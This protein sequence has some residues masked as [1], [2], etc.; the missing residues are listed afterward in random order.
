[1]KKVLIF[2]L[3][4]VLSFS[5]FAMVACQQPCET[6]LDGN[7]DGI[8]DICDTEGLTVTHTDSNHDGK[9]DAGCGATVEVNHVD[10]A[11]DGRCDVCNQTVEIVHADANNDG[12]CD[13]CNVLIDHTHAD[14]NND[15]A[16][17]VP[18]CH[19]EFPWVANLASAKALVN[20][21]YL[22]EATLTPGNYTLTTTVNVVGVGAYSVTWT[23]EVA[24]ADKEIVKLGEP[25]QILVNNKV[26]HDVD[27][28]IVAVIA[29]AEGH[30]TTVSFDRKVPK[31]AENTFAEYAAA[32]DGDYLVVKGIVVA[33][34]SKD[35]G[36]TDNS[37]YIVD[38]D[39]G[40]YVYGLTALPEGVKVGDTV[41]ASG[42]KKTYNGTYE[43]VDAAVEIVDATTSMPEPKDFTDLYKAAAVAGG[44]SKAELVAQQAQLVT[45]KGVT[46]GSV[47]SNG[48]RHFSLDGLESYVRISSSN[49]PLNAADTA[50]FE[51][52]FPGLFGMTAD[53]TGLVTLYNG[54]FYLTPISVDA[55]SNAKLPELSDAEKVAF[56]KDALVFETE[57]IE[58][59]S[60]ELP[61]AG[62]AYDTVA[63]AWDFKAE[64]AHDCATI[65]DGKL[66]VTLPKDATTI[67]LVATLTCGNETATKE[68]VVK[69]ASAKIDWKVTAD[70]LA[71]C[72]A[73]EDGAT[74]E[75]YY[76]FYGTVGEIY[77]TEYCNFYLLDAEGNSI[78]VYG[79]YAPNGTDRYGSKRQISEIPFKEGDLIC[80]RAQVQKFVK[81]GAITPELVNAVHVV[82][83]EKGTEV[84]V[85][86]NA[87]EALAI[88]DALEN[89]ATTENFSYF[90][91][92]VGE[93]YNTGYCNFYLTDANGGSIVVY[94][95][96]A[97]N[98][99]DRYGSNREI[100][101]IPFKQGD[102]IVIYSKVQKYYKSSDGSITPELVNA[103]LVSF[104]APSVPV[105]T[106][107]SKCAV[108]GGC[109]NA[110][111]TE[112][113]CATKC[114]CV[115]QD[116]P[117]AGTY[118]L[119]LVHTGLN[120]TLYF[121]GAM[122]GHYFATTEV[123]A[124][125]IQVV[126]AKLENGK[127]TMAITVEGATKYLAIVPSGTYI[128]VVMQEAAAEWTWNAKLGNFTIDVNG[129]AY[130][131][132]TSSTGTYTTISQR[133]LSDASTTC[134]A[135][136]VALSGGSTGGETPAPHTCESVCPTCQGCLNADCTETACATKC[137]CSTGGDAPA[138]ECANVC[139]DCGKCTNEDCAEAV[140]AEK[141]EG[142]EPVV[143]KG[144]QD[145]PFT[146]AEAI[147]VAKANG[148]TAPAAKQFVKAYITAINSYNSQYNNYEL[149]IADEVGGTTTLK[150]YRVTLATGVE[151]ISIGDLVLIE[152][153]LYC[154]QTT[155]QVQ[156][157]G[158]TNPTLT[159]VTAH[160]CTDFTPADCLN[161]AKCTV[162]GEENGEAFGHTE[163]N[164]EGKCD[165]C[166]ADLETGASTVTVSNTI[167]ALA[168]A[169]GWANSTKYASFTLDENITVSSTGTSNTGKYYTSGEQWRIY[170][171][172]NP[173]V[174]VTADTGYT[175]VSVKIT[176]SVDK[177]GV[178]TLDG[179]N[180]ASGTVVSV[181]GSSIT[182]GVGNTGTANNGQVRITAIEVVYAPVAQ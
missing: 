150:G 139:K 119:K 93:I 14:A 127:Y 117:E 8:C 114:N 53:V 6:H 5:V 85:A 51:A 35:L 99:T 30:S 126:L 174:T 72:D 101:E 149:L 70:A 112:E 9:C 161:A 132:G 23:V 113:A 125:A 146:V 111:C 135:N 133:K 138:H 34:V 98:G 88:C 47:G 116:A 108:C 102:N 105:H 124:D 17:D 57:I 170:Q 104:S 107:E 39:G 29:D 147:E 122:D 94:G 95:L 7:H 45:I 41:R 89:G 140:C 25:G 152:G 137:E 71:T 73:L 155:P 156:Y 43:L 19:Y 148:T 180:V 91:G 129:T 96:Y 42:S 36:D 52:A 145:N 172:E 120:K 175:I 77:N 59:G 37:L 4:V 58:N 181:N 167:A 166:G 136:L 67:T 176:Y 177:T 171:T 56:E 100:A 76:Y 22:K 12:T 66:N 24:E 160:E 141:C 87:T 97:P 33:I 28:K 83:P 121:T 134:Q 151:S 55:F 131:Y 65:A 90:S 10:A 61:S 68:F 46:V 178:L 60:I 11:H 164:A 123:E 40:Y 27:Y 165:R 26:D 54:N 157:S 173:S 80:M 75:D 86:Y 92:V 153:Y 49:C 3:A 115:A 84:F 74:S 32:E 168:D 82:T 21:L 103:V 169:N 38:N 182:F 158:N 142:H 109:E 79:L 64:T 78:V 163:A 31:F 1:M 130:F 20:D 106:C 143:V 154:Y 48:Y 144:T 159:I 118:V 15:G 2:I 18:T 50:A 44:L 81:N 13:V 110:A 69:I 62:A 128:N 179:A 16:C 162:C 63:I